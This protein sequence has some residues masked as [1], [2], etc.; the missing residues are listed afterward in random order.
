[1]NDRRG[2]KQSVEYGQKAPASVE[3]PLSVCPNIR[4]LPV[5]GE[6]AVEEARWQSLVYP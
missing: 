1:M 2:G 6:Y 4:N 5:H 3:S